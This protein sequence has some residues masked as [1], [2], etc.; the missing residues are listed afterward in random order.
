MPKK[1]KHPKD[2]TS[3]EVMAHVFHPKVVKHLRAHVAELDAAKPN[4]PRK[5]QSEPSMNSVPETTPCVKGI[6][7]VRSLLRQ[8]G[9][10][11]AVALRRLLC[12]GL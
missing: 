10:A 6:I 1:P 11:A 3:D 5:R 9:M 12:K 7:T 2:M 4:G 8:M